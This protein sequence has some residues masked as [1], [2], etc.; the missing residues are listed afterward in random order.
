MRDSAM[1]SVMEHLM[2]KQ[3]S[4]NYSSVSTIQSAE[5]AEVRYTVWIHSVP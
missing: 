2:D 4:S 3:D 5:S 1:A